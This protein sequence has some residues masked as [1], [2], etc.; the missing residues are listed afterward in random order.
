MLSFLLCAFLS[1]G[2]EVDCN[3]GLD[4]DG[5]GFIDC[6]DSDCIGNAICN[7]PVLDCTY[8][9]SSFSFTVSGN[10]VIGYIDEY[11]LTDL[12]GIIQQI[13]LVN[14][15][16]SVIPGDYFI[17]HLNYPNSILMMGNSIGLPIGN[18]SGDC[19]EISGGFKIKVCPNSAICQLDLS[20]WLEGAYDPNIGEM[21]TKLNDQ[22]LLPGQ[23]PFFFIGQPTPVGQPFNIPPWNYSGTEGDS[24]DYMIIGDDRANYPNDVVDWVL[25]SLRSSIS[26][27]SMFYQQAAWVLKDGTI[28]FPTPLN[29][30]LTQNQEVFIVIEHPHH[31]SIMTPT[32]IVVGTNGLNFDFQSNQSYKSFTGDGQKLLSNGAFVMYAANGDQNNSLSS[33]VDINAF[34]ESIWTGLNSSGDAYLNGDFNL[35]GDVNALDESI[36][37]NNI[38]KSSDVGF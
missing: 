4:N 10:P 32:A 33:R 26:P 27:S 8:E 2:Q 36:W 3:N 14:S 35:D 1:I 23:K 19:F 20:I 15:F 11:I 17:F 31:L 16:S 38:S 5:D 30:S 24:Y 28:D 18:I 6:S 21:T 7:T 12:N 37:L 29:C 9:G 13:E 34:D 22:Q 25:V